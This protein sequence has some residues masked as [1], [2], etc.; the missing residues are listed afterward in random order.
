MPPRRADQL[1]A[2]GPAKD[3]SQSQR[4][5]EAGVD[6]EFLKAP[7][8]QRGQSREPD[9]DNDGQEGDRHPG[10]DSCA[11]ED[12]L[13]RPSQDRVLPP[14]GSEQARPAKREQ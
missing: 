9:R 14:G 13:E 10:C 7:D 5:S 12:G 8:N 3:D 1:L 11:P 4:K 2:D 6:L